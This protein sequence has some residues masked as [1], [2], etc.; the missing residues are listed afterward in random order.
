MLVLTS[1]TM[2]SFLAHDVME[3]FIFCELTLIPC[4]F[5]ISQWGGKERANAALKFFIYTFVGSAFL[6]LEFFT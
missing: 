3:F 6:S 4:F 5:I 2:G 1:F